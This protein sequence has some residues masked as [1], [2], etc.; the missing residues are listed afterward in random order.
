MCGLLQLEIPCCLDCKVK[1]WCFVEGESVLGA[2]CRIL[3]VAKDTIDDKINVVALFVR[4]N[5]WREFGRTRN[6][7]CGCEVFLLSLRSPM[8]N[9]PALLAF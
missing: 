8:A 2:E 9:P 1:T 6:P 4:V 3:V 5:V 7:M